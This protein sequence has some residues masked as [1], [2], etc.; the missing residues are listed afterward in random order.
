M[1]QEKEGGNFYLWM[2][3]EDSCWFSTGPNN[4]LHF[5]TTE[6]N[7]EEHLIVCAT[8]E[9]YDSTRLVQTA[10]NYYYNKTIK[11]DSSKAEEILPESEMLD[12]LGYCTWNAFGKSV[13]MDNIQQAMKSFQSHHIPISYTIIDDGWQHVIN[14]KMGSMDTCLQKFPHG[15][16]KTISTLKSDFPFL[17]KI[18]IWHVSFEIIKKKCSSI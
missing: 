2:A 17:K 16:K 18:G 10:L 11:K 7:K 12:G 1:Y 8:T 3:I 13:T 4:T 6:D 15:L 14:N 9:E 5:H